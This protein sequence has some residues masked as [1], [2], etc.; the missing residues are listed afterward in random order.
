MDSAQLGVLEVGE[1]IM[2]ATRKQNEA[3]IWRCKF[4]TSTG[5]VAWYEFFALHFGVFTVS[6]LHFSF[7]CRASQTSSTGETVL[8]AL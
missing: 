5:I 7:W 6:K 8:Q 4:L 3:S 2:L 1:T